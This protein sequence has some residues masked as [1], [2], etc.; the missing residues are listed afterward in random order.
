MFFFVFVVIQRRGI[1]LFA[2]LPTKLNA[3]FEQ[4]STI[5][6]LELSFNRYCNI[7]NHDKAQH[8][9]DCSLLFY[10]FGTDFQPWCGNISTACFRP[11]VGGA[12]SANHHRPCLGRLQTLFSEVL[13]HLSCRSTP[14]SIPESFVLGLTGRLRRGGSPP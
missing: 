9:F 2:T 4:K 11:Q 1:R 10:V 5:I 6:T 14:T 7:V 3:S 12:T 13:G 8:S